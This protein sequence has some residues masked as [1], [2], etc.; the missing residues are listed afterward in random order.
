MIAA[1]LGPQM[2]PFGTWGK[3]RMA[4]LL[5]NGLDVKAAGEEGGLS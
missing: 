4:W 5:G 2:D 1:G 3:E